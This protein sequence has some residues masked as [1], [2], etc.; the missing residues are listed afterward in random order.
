MQRNEYGA[1]HVDA[2]GHLESYITKA[3]KIRNRTSAAFWDNK[4]NG[5]R[6]VLL[7]LFK[8]YRRGGKMISLIEDISG[9]ERHLEKIVEKSHIWRNPRKLYKRC[10]ETIRGS[11]L[12]TQSIIRV[13]VTVRTFDRMPT[14]FA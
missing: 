3:I 13:I 11:L 9:I 2:R 12:V 6:W 5:S 8:K 14:P 4:P 7:T 10:D 1:S